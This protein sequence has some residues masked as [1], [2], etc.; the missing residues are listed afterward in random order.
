MLGDYF[1]KP[2][3]G[4][5]MRN[6]RIDIMNLRKDTTSISQEYV[7]AC[8]FDKQAKELSQKENEAINKNQLLNGHVPEMPASEVDD[9]LIKCNVGSYLMAV[10]GLFRN[11]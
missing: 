4:T 8:T 7:E 10:K 1:T 6:S 9:S 11:V 5:R 2:Q 3:Q